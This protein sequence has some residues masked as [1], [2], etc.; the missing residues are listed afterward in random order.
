MSG[1]LNPS[2][3]T[4]EGLLEATS[5]PEAR[6]KAIDD[7]L[8]RMSYPIFENDTT[9]VLL[10]RG[11]A[12]S[13]S[14]VGDMTDWIGCIPF[15]RL[16]GT[17][18]W[19]HRG[20]YEPDARLEYLIKTG[21]A[22]PSAD[23][24]NPD[25]VHGFVLNS[26]LAMPQY[27][28]RPVFEAYRNGRLG[29]FE[30]LAEYSLPA[31]VLSYLHQIHVYLPPD[32]AA[33]A[34]AYPVIYFQ[35]GRDYIEYGV[36]A[37]VVH[38]LIVQGSIPPVIAV[39]VTPP[40]LHLPAVPNR[41]TEYG[42]SDAY[43]RFFCDELVPWVDKSFRTLS[44]PEARVVIGDS[45]GG[46]ISLCIAHRRPDV[47]LAAYSQSGYL[48]FQRDRLLREI[49]T[50]PALRPRIFVDIGTYERRVASGIVP[51]EE[52]D[53]LAA[54]RRFAD[55]ARRA[56]ADIEYR[57]YHEGHTWGNWR[58]HLHDALPHL[59]GSGANPDN[60]WTARLCI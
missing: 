18:L 9:A 40:N 16:P 10:Y 7:F 53:F 55:M 22:S 2:F 49:A 26:E 43:V 17:D 48:S 3:H 42:M 46:L 45:Y 25:C 52:G 11:E 57:E 34:R 14:L 60:E 44:N 41:T 21:D 8:R 33:S 23:P 54:N 47:F 1:T 6:N 15:T 31:N 32:Y 19:F 13:V 30:R 37:E 27:R 51:D 56:G 50:G 35:D 59:L 39:F 12:P 4:L 24:L 28:R 29:E 5:S 20:A 38:Q 36:A 58:A